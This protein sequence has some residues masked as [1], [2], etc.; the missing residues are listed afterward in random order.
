MNIWIKT[1]TWTARFVGFLK[2]HFLSAVDITVKTHRIHKEIIE[3]DSA[4][5]ENVIE[6]IKAA[7]KHDENY[8]KEGANVSKNRDIG[9][10]L[11]EKRS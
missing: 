10:G 11:A 1:Q 8:L 5:L 6:L 7:K 9:E 3:I 2:D 4:E